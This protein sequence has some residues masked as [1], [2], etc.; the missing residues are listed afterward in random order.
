MNKYKCHKEV[1]AKPMTRGAYNQYRG[2]SIPNDEEAS[3]DGYLVVY[4]KDTHD[5]YES[6]SPKKQFDKGYTEIS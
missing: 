2:W 1:H 3:D 4:D 6:W 5:H